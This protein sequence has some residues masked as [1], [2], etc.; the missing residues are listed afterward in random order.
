MGQEV[1]VTPVQLLSA[2]STIANGGVLYRP[3]VVRELRRGGQVLRSEPAAPRRVL[4]PET[5]ATLRRL[6]EGVVLEGTGKLAHLDGYTTA[7][8]TG[9][10][11]KIDPATGRYSPTQYIASFVGFAP[12][13][14]PAVAVVVTLDSPEGR[15]HG[16]SVAAPVFK[17]VTQQVLA[18][19]E[20]PHDVV[21]PPRWLRAA[22]EKM[23]SPA[24]PEVSDF[25]PAQA[26]NTAAAGP[27]PP[28]PVGPGPTGQAQSVV[29]ADGEG[30][31]VP[32]L[33]GKTVREVTEECLWLGLNPVLVGTGVALDQS[34]EAGTKLRRGSRVRV[35]FG[36]PP[37][38]MPT[39]GH[40]H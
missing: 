13:N 39:S 25:D 7:G 6:L 1:G 26:D 22:Q 34:P 8:K 3:H 31:P 21:V 30:I 10:A 23:V 9:T 27:A 14:T 4:R 16:G 5:A 11:Q 24:M 33:R 29:I 38:L 2:V 35:R 37:A 32:R 19:L 15:Y 40:G 17:R 20:V 36:R 18:Y 12:L 28:E